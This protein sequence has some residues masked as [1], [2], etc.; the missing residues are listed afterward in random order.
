M[1]CEKC[2][3]MVEE[4]IALGHKIS[5]KGIEVDKAKLDVI[6]KLPPPSNLKSLRSFL[7]HAEFYG[8][9]MK[10]FSFI[11]KSLCEFLGK[12]VPFTFDDKCLHEFQTQKEKLNSAPILVQLNWSLPFELMCD[13]SNHTMEL[14]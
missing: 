1:N 8:H 7:R 9:S 4:G 2:H 3:S 6:A 12:E 10:D 14:A 5:F 13:A 11:S